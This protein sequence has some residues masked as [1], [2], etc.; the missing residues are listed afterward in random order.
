MKQPPDSL[1]LFFSAV[2]RI[3]LPAGEV[4]GLE[5]DELIERLLARDPGL[6]G[7]LD[8]VKLVAA[9]I[10]D[11][12]GPMIGAAQADGPD[13]DR[14]EYVLRAQIGWRAANLEE[15]KQRALQLGLRREEW[16]YAWAGEPA[17]AS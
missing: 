6:A 9:E 10:P 7:H 15:V 2:W 8:A 17:P 16:T 3:V 5:G 1:P 12:R 13:A 4:N 14:D 11:L